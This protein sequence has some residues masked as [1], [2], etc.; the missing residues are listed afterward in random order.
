MDINELIIYR[1][2][3]YQELFQDMACL[4]GYADSGSRP[5]AFHCAG[6]LV[7]LAVNYGFEGNLWHCFLAF[8]LANN[9][10]AYT[11]SCE[12]TGA[13]GGSLDLRNPRMWRNSRTMWKNSTGSSE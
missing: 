11:T 12:I 4:M 9:E 8:C 6:Q 10:N 5:D 7:E 2:L 1:N 13:A 3:E